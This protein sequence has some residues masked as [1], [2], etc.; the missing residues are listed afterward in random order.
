M[1]VQG[2]GAALSPALGGAIAQAV[3]YRVTFVVLGAFA[4]GSLALWVAFRSLLRPAC[5][6]NGGPEGAVQRR[7]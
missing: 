4:L 1:T 2:V 7:A 3:G 5:D 6:N